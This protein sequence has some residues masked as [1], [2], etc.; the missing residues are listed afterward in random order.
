MAANAL[1]A[2]DILSEFTRAQMAPMDRLSLRAMI[3]A[4]ATDARSSRKMQFLRLPST[5]DLP[6]LVRS[7]HNSPK[8]P[9]QTRSGR[10]G[11]LSLT[12]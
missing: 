11:N 9:S 3:V 8:K 12:I 7:R 5:G 4:L 10:H 2:I 6:V 1:L